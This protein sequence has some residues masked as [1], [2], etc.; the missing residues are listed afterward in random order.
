VERVTL[1]VNPTRIW[2]TDGRKKDEAVFATVSTPLRF[3]QSRPMYQYMISTEK[4]AGTHYKDIWN[5]FVGFSTSP[6]EMLAFGGSVS[7]GNQIAYGYNQHDNKLGR[8]TKA[9]VW[10]DLNLFDRLFI[11]NWVDHVKSYNTE[12]DWEMFYGYIYGSRIS[13]Q[14]NRQLSIRLFSQY[15]EFSDTWVFDPLITYQLTPF[16]LFYIGSTY[17]IQAYDNL[18]RS[19]DRVVVEP[20]EAFWHRKLHSRQFF[21]K[22]QYLFQL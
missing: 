19:G 7:Y 14:Y 5:H 17:N 21:M 22:V 8:Q 16:T 13:L 3:Y 11:E 18:D 20:E 4:F 12:T 9:R 6:S 1:D 10:L 2:N 15:N